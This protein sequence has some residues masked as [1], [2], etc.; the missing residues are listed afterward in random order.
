MCLIWLQVRQLPVTIPTKTH[1]CYIAKANIII[2]QT[3]KILE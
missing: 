2:T 1:A 3:G